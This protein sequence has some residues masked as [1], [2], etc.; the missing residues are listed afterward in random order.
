M[1]AGLAGPSVVL[2]LVLA[3]ALAGCDG[4]SAASGA[5]AAAVPEVGIVEIRAQD[6][7]LTTHLSGRISAFEVSEVR[8]QIGGIVRSRRFVEGGTVQAGQ[9]LYEIDAGPAAAQL[10]STQATAASA[11]AR[12][13]RYQNLIAINA[14]SR[15]E[16]DDA[17][18]AADL[19][20]AQ[21]DAARINLAYTRVT[22]PISGVIGA[23]S[24][25][26]GA[27]AT[28]SQAAPF[29]VI[30]QIDRVYVD[31]TESSADLLRLRDAMAQRGAGAAQAKVRLT[32]EDGS[33]YPHEGVLQFSDVS[34]NP[35]TGTVTLRAVFPNP[36]RLLL[37]GM[38]VQADISQGVSHDA[39]L[40]PQ[41]GV[42]R[43]A[44]GDAVALI[45][46][47]EGVVERRQIET[48]ATTG[49]QWVVTSGLNPGDRLIVD[50]VQHAKPGDHARPVLI[51][52]TQMN[53][54]GREDG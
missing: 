24:V 18:A 12:Y 10:A 17:R 37:P 11:S 33:T 7:E 42:T 35:G 15:Q 34:V 27:L 20:A 6:Y 44:R 14:V 46:N 52:A 48:G 8:P 23:S 39:I 1:R 13:Q 29:A 30:Q 25:T 54:R 49:D 43:N 36:D 3:A 16:L 32:L 9:L 53:L 28:P 41:Q 19:A 5:E 40:A 51:E 47:R 22:A 50:G 4:P 31:M 2:A 26:P 38:F 45:L 21:L